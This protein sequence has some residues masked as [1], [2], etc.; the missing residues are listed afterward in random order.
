MST[1]TEGRHPVEFILSEGPRA[2][3]RDA[4]TIAEEQTIE[5]NQV[6][7]KLPVVAEVT[8]VAAANAGNTSGSGAMTMATP[9][10]SASVKAGVYSVVCVEPASNAGNFAIFD[11]NGKF[12]GKATAAVAFDGEVKFTIADATDFVSGDGFT[13]TVTV[14][15]YEWVAFDQ[16]GTDGSEIPAGIALYGATTGESES[17]KIS[18]IV[19]DAEV[20]GNCVVWPSDIEADEKAAG[21]LG[22]QKLGIIT[23]Y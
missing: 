1:L 7:A 12:I 3:S 15:E 8:A 19:R 18:A 9:A 5:P 16:D 2:R 21:E 23:R 13:I 10:V 17:A 6:V 14:G 11:P 20:N 22:L 4:I